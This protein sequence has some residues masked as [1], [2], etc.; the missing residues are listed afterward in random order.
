M[1]LLLARFAF[2]VKANLRRARQ[3]DLGSSGSVP[4]DGGRI[5]N[6]MAT[7]FRPNLVAVRI[8]RYLANHVDVLG[9]GFTLADSISDVVN[10]LPSGRESFPPDVSNDDGPTS[11]N[12]M[13][14]IQAVPAF[15]VEVWS[16]GDYGPAAEQSMA[17]KRTDYF[18]AGTQDVWDVDSRADL[19]H[20]YRRE[21]PDQPTTFRRGQVADAE[22]A[23]PE[24]GVEVDRI[25][26]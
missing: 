12:E 14:F 10:E 19:I 20:S 16:E 15:A 13:R 8:L 11:L 24:W 21:L 23:V 4:L 5:V 17:E 25:F 9:R 26:P 3:R 6:L 22:P 18:A 1:I 7:G 2:C